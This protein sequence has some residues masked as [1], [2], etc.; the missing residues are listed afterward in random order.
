VS[1][2]RHTDSRMQRPALSVMLYS[3]VS[4]FHNARPGL[5]SSFGIGAGL[6]GGNFSRFKFFNASTFEWRKSSGTAVLRAR[7]GPSDHPPASQGP[8]HQLVA[9]S[10]KSSR[11]RRH[12]IKTRIKQRSHKITSPSCSTPPLSPQR[13]QVHFAPPM[14]FKLKNSFLSFGFNWT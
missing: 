14:R 3:C 12:S 8:P 9:R 11:R 6:F 10:P 2:L 5:P 1:S 4:A 7:A 13:S